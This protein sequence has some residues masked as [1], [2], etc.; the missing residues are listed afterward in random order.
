MAKKTDAGFLISA[1]NILNETEINY[2]SAKNKRLHVELALIRLT[3]LLQAIELSSAPDGIAKKKLVDDAKPVAF[4]NIPAMKLAATGKRETRNEKREA[5]N[6]KDETKIEIAAPVI[7]EAASPAKETVQPST[8]AAQN[9]PSVKS[10]Q[11]DRLR[12]QIAERTNAAESAKS[13]PLGQQLLQEAWNNYTMRLKESK[14]PAAQSFEL[15][16]LNILSES[17]FEVITNNNLEH[18]FI[19]QEKRILSEHLQ[20]TFANKLLNFTVKITENPVEFTP[21]EK[22]L[23]KRD[24]FLMMTEQYPLIKE[25]KE[26]LKL[27]LDY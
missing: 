14:N 22:T 23:S 10:S 8:E 4:R 2:K 7:K 11:L 24:Q 19:E 18:K 17:S 6:G 26:R 5:E 15:A 20:K 27:D 25:L 21:A 16:Q 1:L 9:N 13:I 12:K 3:Y